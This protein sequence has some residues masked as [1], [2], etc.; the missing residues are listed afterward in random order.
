MGP[1][2]A[3][4]IYAGRQMGSYTHRQRD[5]TKVIS[6]FWD[7]A[8]KPKN[9]K[10]VILITVHYIILYCITCDGQF[11]SCS[12]ADFITYCL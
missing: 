2:G 1:L 6:A 12:N 3:G 11:C 7:Y 10:N 9:H 5:M 4:L 8:N